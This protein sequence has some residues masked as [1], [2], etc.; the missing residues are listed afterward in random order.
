[1]QHK[2]LFF[3]SWL[4]RDEDQIRDHQRFATQTSSQIL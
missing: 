1:L 4:Q 3:E 2:L